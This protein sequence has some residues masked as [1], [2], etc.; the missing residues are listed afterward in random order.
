MFSKSRQ[1][2]RHTILNSRME[3]VK[4][5]TLTAFR[6]IEYYKQTAYKN[7]IADLKR[8]VDNDHDYVKYIHQTYNKNGEKAGLH[9]IQNVFMQNTPDLKRRNLFINTLKGKA[10]VN[11]RNP[12]RLNSS[13]LDLQDYRGN[14]VVHNELD[15]MSQQDTATLV[16]QLGMDDESIFSQKVTFIRK[17]EPLGIYIGESIYLEDYVDEIKAQIIDLLVSIRFGEQG[18][19]FLNTMDGYSLINLGQKVEKPINIWNLTDPNGIK[20]IQEEYKAAKKLNGDY[21][22]YSW[23]KLNSE[24]VS[25]KVSF[26]KGIEDF[27]W[28][29]GSG[30]YIDDINKLIKAKEEDMRARLL[31]EMF[32]ISGVFFAL[33]FFGFIFL[34]RYLKIEKNQIQIFTDY[35]KESGKTHASINTEEIKYQE[36]NHMADALNLMVNERIH[37]NNQLEKDRLLMRYVIDAIPDVIWYKSIGGKFQGCNKAFEKTMGIS[38][39]FILDKYSKEVFSLDMQNKLA[40]IDALLQNE[41]DTVREEIW[42]K[43]AQGKLL[44]L[45][46][47]KSYYYDKSGK[48]IGTINVARDITL[49]ENQRKSLNEALEKANQSDQLKTAFITNVSHEIRTPLNSIMGFASTIKEEEIEAD[50]IPEMM[51]KIIKPSEKLLRV[52]ENIMYLSM[53]E[54]NGLHYSAQNKDI[55]EIFHSVSQDAAGR[56]A[57]LKSNEVAFDLNF[58][59]PTKYFTIDPD[60]LRIIFDCVLDNAFKYTE[61]GNVRVAVHMKN[62]QLLVDVCDSGMG[63]PEGYEKQIYRSFYQIPNDKNKKYHGTGCGLYIAKYLLSRLNGLIWYESQLALGTSFHFSFPI[64]TDTTSEQQDQISET[65]DDLAGKRIIIIDHK[66]ESF[67]FIRIMLSRLSAHVIRVKQVDKLEAYARMHNPNLIIIVW[68]N[69][70]LSDREYLKKIAACCNIPKLIITDHK[71]AADELEVINLGFKAVLEQPIRLKGLYNK[72]LEVLK[73]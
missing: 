5:E 73:K 32:Y 1:D 58:D 26:I 68:R 25:D 59:L 67:E 34:R 57:D 30:V 19:V 49:R 61:K 53:I 4:G 17:Y 36:F 3:K 8:R 41:K 35:F 70:K 66:D 43:D 39:D 21:I 46:V 10:I 52:F 33:L 29:L 48:A 40:S 54:T 12:I 69:D 72:M 27:G 16:Y 63:I 20:V 71:S 11:T 42:V 47:I 9:E 31:R 28:M 65:L 14:S 7:V 56:F 15:M 22:Y 24:E 50:E 23:K 55:T 44:L 60:W 62:N 13:L 64:I 38:R 6:Y 51:D 18:Y 37:I 2:V 45:D